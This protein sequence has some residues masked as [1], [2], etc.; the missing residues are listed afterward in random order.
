MLSER[1][2]E[3][4][5]ITAAGR[6]YWAGGDDAESRTWKIEDTEDSDMLTAIAGATDLRALANLFSADHVERGP[7]RIRLIITPTG[8][9]ALARHKRAAAAIA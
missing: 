5:T 6:V 9:R 7:D 1:E 3:L 8:T 4:L 2:F